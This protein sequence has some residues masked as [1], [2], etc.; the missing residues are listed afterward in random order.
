MFK[1]Y[2]SVRIRRKIMYEII[3]MCEVIEKNELIIIQIQSIYFFR[4]KI[5]YSYSYSR[6]VALTS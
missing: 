6:K 1:C 3:A 2:C 5:D 4:K